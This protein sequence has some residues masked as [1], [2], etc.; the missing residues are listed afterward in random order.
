MAESTPLAALSGNASSRG[1]AKE[2]KLPKKRH[3]PA[4]S[5]AS[6]SSSSSSG[7]PAAASDEGLGHTAPDPE[8]A[9][10]VGDRAAKRRRKETLPLGGGGDGG[11][12]RGGGGDGGG[13]WVA[14]ASIFG[15][16]LFSQKLSD[17]GV[18]CTDEHA[19]A[20][21]ELYSMP[22]KFENALR[23]PG[24]AEQFLEHLEE[25]FDD[26]ALRAVC[27]SPMADIETL[28]KFAVVTDGTTSS[29]SSF[30]SSSSELDTSAASTGMALRFAKLR[31]QL[32]ARM[33][34]KSS[35]SRKR[36]RGGAAATGAT[37]AAV[38]SLRPNQTAPIATVDL[39]QQPK[40]NAPSILLVSRVAD[41][42]L[43]P[44][45]LQSLQRLRS[46]RRTS[47]AVI[48]VLA[49]H[50]LAT[51]NAD[52]KKFVQQR[53]FFYVIV[54]EERAQDGSA[55]V[56][57]ECGMVW[58]VGAFKSKASRSGG[59]RALIDASVALKR[60]GKSFPKVAKDW[61][62]LTELVSDGGASSF[63]SSSSSSSS[64]RRRRNFGLRSEWTTR[65]PSRS[66]TRRLP[67]KSLKKFCLS[68]AA[69]KVPRDA[70]SSTSQRA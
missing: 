37:G 22:Q 8:L 36:R 33:G 48:C 57:S 35:R 13:A 54:P 11:G 4:S 38:V 3:P 31:E 5:S 6:S 25:L 43:F 63:S 34:T 68:S 10:Q 18:R 15:D 26:T 21:A 52:W 51:A 62:R 69:C 2:K 7:S 1:G 41:P 53:D 27:L 20:C 70:P 42:K 24:D 32:E 49:P 61:A 59:M 14:L 46:T 39:L 12:G 16:S 29:S 17:C 55:P 66:P 50:S 23:E 44:R 65:R 45:F 67:M 40:T 60:Q 19:L 58:Y 28:K 9:G 47:V 56:P 30:S 64:A